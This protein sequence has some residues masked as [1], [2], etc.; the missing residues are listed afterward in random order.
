MIDFGL[1]KD[2]TGQNQMT[3]MSGSPYYIAPEVIKK[4]YNEK[5]DLWSAGVILYILIS[6]QPPFSGNTDEDTFEKIL[7]SPLQFR[8]KVFNSTSSEV[9]ELIKNLLDKNPKTRIT[10][11]ECLEDPWLKIKSF[12]NLYK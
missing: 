12:E 5:C 4:N 7:N 11:T 3:T 10:I 9:K 8:D 6:G 2:F 1:S